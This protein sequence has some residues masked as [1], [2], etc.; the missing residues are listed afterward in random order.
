MKSKTF[1]L[2]VGLVLGITAFLL[3][4]ANSKRHCVCN[5]SGC[6][7]V[8][9]LALGQTPAPDSQCGGAEKVDPTAT[10]KP[11]NPTATIERPTAAKIDPS[12]TPGTK[13]IITE[14]AHNNPTATAEKK[15]NPTVTPGQ[16]D[17]ATQATG[18]KVD[19]ALS[20]PITTPCANCQPCPDIRCSLA[21]VA[22]SGATQAAAQAT[23][24]EFVSEMP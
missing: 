16:Q 1:Y 2:I 23:Q 19:P 3:I 6:H 20:D 9:G 18:S 7:W 5:P 24:A 12:A 17:K 22:A 13:V 10:E 14:P 8:S 21:T 4:G 15:F 11:K